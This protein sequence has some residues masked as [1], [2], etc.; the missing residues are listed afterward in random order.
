MS[1]VIGGGNTVNN[2]V[3]T[4][5][6]GLTNIGLKVD[7]SF[8]GTVTFEVCHGSIGA[9]WFPL[10][11]SDSGATT[12]TLPGTYYANVATWDYIRASISD[13]TSGSITM[14]LLENAQSPE[15]GDS[16]QIILQNVATSPGI[17]TPYTLQGE[18]SIRLGI[19]G[20]ATSVNIDIEV[21]DENGISSSIEGRGLDG[22]PVL[23]T[24]D[25][26]THTTIW[27]IDNL[28]H[29]KGCQIQANITAISG[30]NLTIAGKAIF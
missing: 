10:T 22:M 18:D 30:G 4:S 14:T 25:I 17:G 6:H 24:T 2:G 21:V 8:V 29:L 11:V 15:Q 19:S 13:Y 3:P 1:M 26:A 16:N 23:P 20:T 7:G 5:I 9:H 28:K 27:L 12:T